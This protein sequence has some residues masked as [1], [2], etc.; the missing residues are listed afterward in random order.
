MPLDSDMP[1]AP[2]LKKELEATINSKLLFKEIKDKWLA[3]GRTEN[4][5]N[6]MTTEE[7]NNEID[8]L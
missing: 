8:C 5:W 3:S 4:D 2:K 6:S 7:R 1:N